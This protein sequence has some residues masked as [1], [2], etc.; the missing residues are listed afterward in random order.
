MGEKFHI[1]IIIA[2]DHDFF[3]KGLAA[4][5]M[6]NDRYKLIDQAADGEELLEK[7]ALHQP[8]LILL[9]VAMPKMD[10]MEAARIISEQ[11]P[12]IKIVALTVHDDDVVIRNMVKSGAISFLDKNINAEQV[13]RTIDEVMQ[14]KSL[15]FPE[16]IV[17]RASVLME[18]QPRYA[19]GAY[20]KD[21]SARELEIIALS[22]EDL[23][24]K[25]IAVRLD[26]SPRTVET[27]RTRIM[28]RMGVKS[29]AGLVAYAFN[30]RL[31]MKKKD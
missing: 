23:S 15:Y 27:H 30:Q 14:S 11:Y 25:E 29:V 22:C 21:F 5:I 9:D 8:D 31:F 2:D 3:R 18:D 26:I 17:R 16:K 4:V 7:L 13:Y 12:L 1:K 24:I 20:K 28:Q 19:N 10:G 6:E